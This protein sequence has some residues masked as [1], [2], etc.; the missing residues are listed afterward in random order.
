MWCWRKRKETRGRH[1]AMFVHRGAAVGPRCMSEV[2]PYPL[3]LLCGVRIRREKRLSHVIGWCMVMIMLSGCAL[4]TSKEDPPLRPVTAQ[5]L[6]TLLQHREAAIQ[7]LKGLFSA[8]VRGGLLPIAA[9]IEGTVYYRRPNAVRLRGFT[10][11]GG[12]LFDLVQIND[13]YK[14][15]LPQEGKVYVGHRSDMNELGKLARL[16]QLSVWAVG[17]LLGMHSVAKDERV[18][19]VEERDGYRLDVY[20]SAASATGSSRTPIRRLWFDRR[21]LVVHEEW[22]GTGGEV[23]ATIQYDDF[24]PLDKVGPTSTQ[25]MSEQDVRLFR[26]YKISLEDGR[27]QGSVQVTFH[28]IHHN[29]AIKIDDIGEIS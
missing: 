14:L 6:T 19:V 21:L 24:R 11:F 17:G 28:E 5:E 22:L 16:S 15:R 26:P 7:S 13:R 1:A 3:L 18:Q 9:R 25:A 8:K 2:E 10:P 29:L 20:A 23:E 12:E 4:V 27:G